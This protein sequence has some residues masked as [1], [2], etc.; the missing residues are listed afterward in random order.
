MIKLTCRLFTC[1]IV[2]V[3]ITAC[4]SSGSSLSDPSNDDNPI[5][6]TITINSIRLNQD[7]TILL[8]EQQSG[9]ANISFKLTNEL[10][11]DGFQIIERK[12]SIT[13]TDGT[14]TRITKLFLTSDGLYYIPV[15]SDPIK[16]FS[17]PFTYEKVL[18]SQ[19]ISQSVIELTVKSE[20][21]ELT[22]GSITYDTIKSTIQSKDG[23]FK[24]VIYYTDAIHMVRYEYLGKVY[25]RL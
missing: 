4:S 18:S 3:G 19:L 10:S 16:L 17:L 11:T 2:L 12:I 23:S 9:T 24:E 25:E 15:G 8:K 5:S 14:D 22:I 21:S 20:Y 7:D 1:F 13:S 6:E